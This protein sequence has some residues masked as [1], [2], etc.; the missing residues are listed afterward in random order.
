VAGSLGVDPT[1]KRLLGQEKGA[2][3]TQ[4][5]DDECLANSD[6]QIHS[7][8]VAW[9]HIQAECTD[10]VPAIL[11][12]LAPNGPFAYT[13]SPIPQEGP[14]DPPLVRFQTTYAGIE[15]AYEALHVRIG[16]RD[17]RS[18]V[19]IRGDWYT[20]MYGEASR[21][22]RDTGEISGAMTAVIFPTLGK[23]GITGELNWMA[24]ANDAGHARPRGDCSDDLRVLARHEEFL[25]ML[26]KGDVDSLVKATHPKAQVGIRDYVTD[27][28]TITDIHDV[29]GVKRYLTAFYDRYNVQG[30]EL[31][32][33]YVNYW[34]AFSE[35]RWTVDDRTSGHVAQFNTIEI[36][37]IDDAG[38]FRARIGHGT[39]VK[40]LS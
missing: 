7:G 37:D 12:T 1:I 13:P 16:V 14:D 21:E 3:L 9:R 40:V 27:S 4:T 5:F 17:M 35:L 22:H 10:D 26:R 39:D 34:S 30:L 36:S 29:D 18:I 38:V 2:A 11:A 20:F 33:R 28:R 23:L 8:N 19:E 25:D 32:E 15:E 31:V 6:A 24:G